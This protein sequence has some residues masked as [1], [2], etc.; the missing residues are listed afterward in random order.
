MNGTVEMCEHQK[1]VTYLLAIIRPIIHSKSDQ[2]DGFVGEPG[3]GIAT[4]RLGS[5]Q[6]LL[7]D[8]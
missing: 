5:S 4:P 2:L 3:S 7:G 6:A 1:S 8:D